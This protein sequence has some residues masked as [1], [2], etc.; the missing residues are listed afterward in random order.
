MADREKQQ[1]DSLMAE[2]KELRGEITAYS[3]RIDRAIGIYLSALFALFAF[4]LAPQGDFSLPAYIQHVQAS[5][6]L[7]GASH[8]IGLLNCLLLTRIQSFYLAVLALSQYTAT[9]ISPRIS[10][11]VGTPVLTWDDAEVTAAK[12]YWLPVRTVAQSG[13]AVFAFA[14]SAFVAWGTFPSDLTF[15]WVVAGLYVLLLAGLGYNLYVFVRI[16]QV[17]MDFHQSAEFHKLVR[18]IKLERGDA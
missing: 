16:I 4:L 3:Q 15:G 14:L 12:R 9:V 17:G 8:L 6:T 2:Y 13:F 5:T 11:L 10:G 1:Y 7:T 18:R